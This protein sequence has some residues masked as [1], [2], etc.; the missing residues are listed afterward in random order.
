MWVSLMVFLVILMDFLL[1]VP[2]V[3]AGRRL[4]P[5]SLAFPTLWTGPGAGVLSFQGV[6]VFY[7]RF[8]YMLFVSEKVS[9]LLQL[10]A[11]KGCCILLRAF[12]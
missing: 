5:S 12:R 11:R 9:S 8:C 1:A 7:H 4:L 10:F 6:L 2:T 3:C